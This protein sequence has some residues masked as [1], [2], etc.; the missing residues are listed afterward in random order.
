MDGRVTDHDPPAE[1][2]DSLDHDPGTSRNPLG[3]GRGPTRPRTR[4]IPTQAAGPPGKY[5][6]LTSNNP[7]PPIPPA[8]IQATTRRQGA[9]EVYRKHKFTLHRGRFERL[10]ELVRIGNYGSI[11]AQAAGVSERT[12]RGWMQRGKEIN[13]WVEEQLDGEID[14]ELLALPATATWPI[15]P[16]AMFA[17]ALHANDWT[18]W[19]LYRHIEQAHGE[20]EAYAVGV[21]RKHMPNSWQAAI[22]WL[23]R[24]KPLRWQKRETHR[25]EGGAEFTV[26]DQALLESQ[27]AQEFLHEAIAAAARGALP[28]SHNES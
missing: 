22:T 7:H 17:G 2:L 9:S 18:C 14:D 28:Q 4:R 27:Q 15:E 25:F 8:E 12:Y 6:A 13:E 16:P 21:V 10:V 20:A 24:S 26:A 11:A 5:P 23:E 1:V 19:L 3:K